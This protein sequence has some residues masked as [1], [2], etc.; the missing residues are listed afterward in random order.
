[1]KIWKCPKPDFSYKRN[2]ASIII[3]TMIFCI[4]VLGIASH[5]CFDTK[6]PWLLGGSLGKTIFYTFDMNSEKSIVIGG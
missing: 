5:G 6:F 2:Q 4:L 1:M 3:K